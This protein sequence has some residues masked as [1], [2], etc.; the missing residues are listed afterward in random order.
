[1]PSYFEEGPFS[2]K[3]TRKHKFRSRFIR[4]QAIEAIVLKRY[5][6][7]ILSIP[8]GRTSMDVRPA[9]LTDVAMAVRQAGKAGRHAVEMEQAGEFGERKVHPSRARDDEDIEV[10]TG[11]QRYIGNE[12]RVST[13]SS[14]S[15]SQ[16]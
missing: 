2:Y 7:D 1:M 3:Y 6:L 5:F 15:T 14:T 16:T 9:A 13:Q 8:R 12:G 11:E 4:D 10:Q